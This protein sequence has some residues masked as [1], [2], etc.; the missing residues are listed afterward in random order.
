MSNYCFIHSCC[1]ENGKTERLDYLINKLISTGCISCFTKIFIINIGHCLVNDYIKQFKNEN[2]FEIINYSTNINLQES[3]T[4]NK[5][6]LFSK[7]NKNCN[8]LYI[9]TKGVRYSIDD[10][11]QND[12]INMMTY[13]LLYKYQ[14]CLQLLN[15]GYSS[16]GC[17]YNEDANGVTKRHYSGNFW[18]AKSNHLH[19]LEYLKENIDSR[20]LVEFHLFTVDHKYFVMHNS[21]I[22][23]YFE[24]YPQKNYEILDDEQNLKKLNK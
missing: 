9:H 19:K 13:F 23:H 7:N 15:D 12:W 17:N 4:F 21:K 2:K 20:S 5:M 22:N 18:W 24:N 14:N 16:V 8:V 6:I 1:L 3:P 10:T 11:K